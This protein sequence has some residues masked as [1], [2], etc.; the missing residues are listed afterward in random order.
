MVEYFDKEDISFLE[1]YT[2]GLMSPTRSAQENGSLLMKKVPQYIIDDDQFVLDIMSHY[3]DV[4]PDWIRCTKVNYVFRF[5]PDKFGLLPHVDHDI[6]TC[7]VTKGIMK[8]VIV[9]ANPIWKK[10]WKG[11]TFFAPFERYNIHSTRYVAKVTKEEFEKDATLVEN[12]PGRI[13]VFDAD[14]IHAP[15]EFSG[16]TVQRLNFSTLLVH[17]DHQW[18]VDQL[19]GSTEGN[20]VTKVRSP[21]TK[22]L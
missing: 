11:G 7:K 18:I 10:E 5:E 4:Y 2:E 19:V 14:E 17:P 16:N 1:K 20:I 6:E 12:V 22:N 21:D 13:V 8:R 3:D 15:Q 9:Y